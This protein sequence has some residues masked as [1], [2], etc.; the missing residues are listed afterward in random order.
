MESQD[1]ESAHEIPNLIIRYIQNYT[2]LVP[3]SDLSIFIRK[4]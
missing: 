2:V 1:G 3:E 4:K